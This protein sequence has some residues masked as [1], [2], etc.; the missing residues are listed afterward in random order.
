MRFDEILYND[1]LLDALDD[2]RFTECTPIQ[3]Q[4]IPAAESGR[5]ILALAQTGTGKTA[6]YLLP[7]IDRLA[8]GGYPE[9][10]VNC[11]VMAPTR[12][13]ALQIDQQMQGFSY[14]L[15]QISSAAIYGGT[16]GKHYDVQKQAL[17][18]GADVVIATPGRL[19]AHLQMGYVDLSRVS[20]FV[21]DEADRMLD[22][23]FVDDIVKIMSYLPKEKQVMMFSATIS[24]KIKRLADQL[25]VDPIEIKIALS[26]PPET[27]DQ[28][29]Y[30][31]YEAQK[32]D[33]LRH[34]LKTIPVDR[35]IIFSSSKQNVKLLSRKIRSWNIN[36]GEIHSDL[37]QTE[38]E[39][40]ML[41][42]R[43]GRINVLV[44]TDIVARG[45]DID[46][47]STII[48]YD[49]P[50][51]AE[52]YVHRIGRT[53]RASATGRAI[54]FVGEKER[55]KFRRIERL[56][57]KVEPKQPLPEGLGESP[58]Y[59]KTKPSGRNHGRKDRPKRERR[60]GDKPRCEGRPQTVSQDSATTQPVQ[61]AGTEPQPKKKPKH[62]HNH[63][64]RKP[65]ANPDG[66]QPQ[67]SQTNPENK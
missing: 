42:F 2:M 7:I 64:R 28:Q 43:S 17:V 3:E 44:A 8:D 60:K 38:R 12:E 53:A 41:D 5:D 63:H 67:A 29:A 13:L 52:D 11:V 21:L 37:D 40:V 15:P 56:I 51:E 6:A 26:K 36:A 48:N 1:D 27:I 54:T 34:V 59:G 58:S 22:M 33:V 45:I 49:V 25:L 10:A 31:L 46:D 18:K 47:I 65:K 30:V 55:E 32:P 19:I 35:I 39:R 9:D 4:A 14:F 16:D 62:R 23:G 57:D 24:P 20:F 61:Q 50:H 66:G